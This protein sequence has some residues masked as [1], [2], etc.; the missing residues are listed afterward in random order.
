MSKPLVMKHLEVTRVYWHSVL[1]FPDIFAIIAVCSIPCPSQM[2][3]R[4]EGYT[5]RHM[6]RRSSEL[7]CWQSAKSSL[8][9]SPSN[10]DRQLVCVLSPFLWLQSL[11]LGAHCM[12]IDNTYTANSLT[13]FKFYMNLLWYFLWTLDFSPHPRYFRKI[14]LVYTCI[15]SWLDCCLS[16]GM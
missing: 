1:Q 6:S 5:N 4:W 10:R 16:N 11:Y 14:E 8:N 7:I 15:E 13:L 3:V 12:N 9:R 2:L